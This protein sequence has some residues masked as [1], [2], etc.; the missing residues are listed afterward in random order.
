MNE[1]HR[2]TTPGLK[3]AEWTLIADLQRLGRINFE[4]H[5]LCGENRW[6]IDAWQRQLSLDLNAVR[7]ELAIR[8]APRAE[9]TDAPTAMAS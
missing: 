3:A 8:T 9:L 2:L 5:N 1:W 6:D 7:A 4:R